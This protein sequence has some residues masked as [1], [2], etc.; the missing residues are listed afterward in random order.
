V[1]AAPYLNEV[2][3]EYAPVGAAAQKKTPPRF[4]SASLQ[5]RRSLV[6][7]RPNSRARFPTAGETRGAAIRSSRL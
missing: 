3:A 1:L 4:C 7:A 2:I 5:G 6:R